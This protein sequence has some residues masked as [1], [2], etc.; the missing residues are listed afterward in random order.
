[1]YGP[2]A[3]GPAAVCAMRTRTAGA[4]HGL[5]GAV[6]RRWSTRKSPSGSSG[7]AAD[8]NAGV[9]LSLQKTAAATIWTG[10]VVPSRPATPVFTSKR[11]SPRTRT[12]SARTRASL[13]PIVH[14]AP[15]GGT[16]NSAG[17][18]GVAV[19]GVLPT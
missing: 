18:G 12:R 13:R 17:P 15:A 3:T 7:T 16:P 8:V 6:V 11:P 4:R 19:V 14:G 9:V 5:A 2:F 10:P 1:M